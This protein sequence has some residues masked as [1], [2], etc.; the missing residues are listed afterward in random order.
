MKIISLKLGDVEVVPL[1]NQ[2]LFENDKISFVVQSDCLS[3][4]AALVSQQIVYYPLVI[5]GQDKRIQREACIGNVD[6]WGNVE[7]LLR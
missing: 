1:E 3:R 7:L 4:I 5:Y 6:G 2:C